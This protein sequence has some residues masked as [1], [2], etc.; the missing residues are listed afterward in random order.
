[1]NLIKSAAQKL[2]ILFIVFFVTQACSRKSEVVNAPVFCKTGDTLCVDHE[3]VLFFLPPDTMRLAELQNALGSE[4][5]PA[6]QPFETAARSWMQR[7]E[8]KDIKMQ[9]TTCR[10]I[11]LNGRVYDTPE[12]LR[13]ALIRPGSA[14]LFLSSDSL[15]LMSRR[16]LQDFFFSHKP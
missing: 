8:L 5:I 14:P 7:S 9:F 13:C 12:S 2:N 3:A 16:E 4:S 6:W 11:K 10:K 1:M 15:E